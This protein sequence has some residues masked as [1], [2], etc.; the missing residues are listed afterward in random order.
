MLH[1]LHETNEN[2]ISQSSFSSSFRLSDKSTGAN[3]E[4][5]CT[6]TL[7]YDFYLTY[8]YDTYSDRN[9]ASNHVGIIISFDFFGI[10]FVNIIS[11]TVDS[12]TILVCQSFDNKMTIM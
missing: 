10:A 5:G 11:E 8:E 4:L 6:C 7:F 9:R 12:L 3:Y 2:L 1:F